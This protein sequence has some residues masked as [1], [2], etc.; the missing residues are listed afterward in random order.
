MANQSFF[1]T[2]TS[3][4]WQ[5]CCGKQTSLTSLSHLDPINPSKQF[6]SMLHPFLPF[7]I[8]LYRSLFIFV[9]LLDTS[10]GFWWCE[11]SKSTPFAIPVWQWRWGYWHYKMANQSFF[12]TATSTKWQTCC[13]KQTSLSHL[14]PKD[15]SK[16]FLSML[17]PYLPFF[18]YLD[19]SLLIFVLLLDMS[20]GFW[21]CEG[22]I[23]T[24]FAIRV[25]QW[26]WGY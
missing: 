22:G 16:Q 20:G 13:G 21:W 17:H 8:Y 14:D 18:I 1:Q 24:P 7:F 11:G 2:A 25:W 26:R 23:A 6:L 10:G 3:T 19:Q 9:L 5:T 15:P 12:Q 4:K